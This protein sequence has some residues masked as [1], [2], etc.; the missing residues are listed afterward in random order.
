MAVIPAPFDP[1]PLDAGLFD[2]AIFDTDDQGGDFFELPVKL[3]PERI[4]QSRPRRLR[5]AR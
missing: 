5:R 2:S 4:R 1:G 3:T